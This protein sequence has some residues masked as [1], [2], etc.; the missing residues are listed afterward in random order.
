MLGESIVELVK[1]IDCSG[2]VPDDLLFLVSKPYATGTQETFRTYA[3]Q[4][5]ASIIS[6]DFTG[7][8]HEIIHNI[9]NF[10]QNLLQSNDYEPSKGGIK[11]TEASVI[12]GMIAKLSSQMDKLKVSAGSNTSTSSTNKSNVNGRKCFICGST[13]HYQTNCPKIPAWRKEKPTEGEPQEKTVEGA[14]YKYCSKCH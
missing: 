1:Q 5:Y 8:Y 10:Y 4:I 13:D 14:L 3:Q 7:D 6:G 12:Q 2:S 9:N 11:E